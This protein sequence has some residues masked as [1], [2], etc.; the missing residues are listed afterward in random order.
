MSDQENIDSVDPVTNRD[1]VEL[2][3]KEIGERYNELVGK[4]KKYVSKNEVWSK[5]L[6]KP[7]R[8]D[9]GKMSVDPA[10]VQMLDKVASEMIEGGR[11]YFGTK[12]REKA[13]LFRGEIFGWKSEEAQGPAY[14]MLVEKNELGIKMLAAGQLSIALQLLKSAEEL[15]RRSSIIR[16]KRER[17]LK[18][19]A[20]TYNNLGCYFKKVRKFSLALQHL[21][22][23]L[24]IEENNGACGN[25]ASTHINICVILSQMSRH[26]HALEHVKSAIGLLEFADENISNGDSSDLLTIAY[27]NKGVELEYLHLDSEALRAYGRAKKRAAD[28]LE[29]SHP[30]SKNI[31]ESFASLEAKVNLKKNTKNPLK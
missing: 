13:V 16:L 30:L 14:R 25:P 19:R 28:K 2:T 9:L 15:S 5:Q 23:G 27:F 26:T 20:I 10:G 31:H 21:L 4:P 24:S 8:I 12:Y 7:C 6:P 3:P 22:K 1:S 18:A 11:F 17:R 29:S